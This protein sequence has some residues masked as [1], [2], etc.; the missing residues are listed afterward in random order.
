MHQHLSRQGAGGRHSFGMEWHLGTPG[1]ASCAVILSIYKIG[2]GTSYVYFSSTFL[3]FH[4]VRL[5]IGV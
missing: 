5:T 1:A 2:L 4:V 3:I